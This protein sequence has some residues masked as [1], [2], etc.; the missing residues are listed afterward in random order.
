[1][2]CKSGTFCFAAYTEIMGYF[3]RD[4]VLFASKQLL[5]LSNKMG[6]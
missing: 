3:R 6:R 2:F 1:M 4:T 5:I